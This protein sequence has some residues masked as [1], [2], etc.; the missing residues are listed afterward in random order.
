MLEKIS[1]NDGV[2]QIDPSKIEGKEM[3][4]YLAFGGNNAESEEFNRLYNAIPDIRGYK[5]KKKKSHLAWEI[6]INLRRSKFKISKS[7]A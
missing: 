7:N 6:W 2:L 3:A 4:I 1:S 5:S